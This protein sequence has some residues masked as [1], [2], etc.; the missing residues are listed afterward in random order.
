MWLFAEVNN[1]AKH[2]VDTQETEKFNHTSGSEE[3]AYL[4]TVVV[5]PAMSGWLPLCNPGVQS[6]DNWLT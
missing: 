4:S 6:D 2:T 1:S 5:N 3:Y